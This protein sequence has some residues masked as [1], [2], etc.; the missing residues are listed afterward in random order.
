VSLRLLGGFE[1]RLVPGG[2]IALPKR[3]S[4]ALLA[5]L[6]VGPNGA[7]PRDT[8]TALLWA[9]VPREQA[10]N[11]LRQTLFVLRRAL[12]PAA[13]ELIRTDGDV[14]V[15]DRA[16]MDVDVVA[17]ERL[18]RAEGPEALERAVMLYGGDLLAGLR[19]DETSFEDWLAPRREELR[20]LALRGLQRFLEQQ[21]AQGH[22]QPALETAT[23]LLTLDPLQESAHHAA[24]RLHA[25]QGNIAAALRQYE[26]YRGIV[27]RELGREP[28]VETR[29]LYHA[30]RRRGLSSGPAPRIEIPLIGRS[31]ESDALRQNLEAAWARRTQVVA[32]LGEAGI[33]KS[34][35]VD[36]V[37][38]EAVRRRGHV[39][40]GRCYETQ[41]ILPF[42]PW[43][44]AVRAGGM[45]ADEIIEALPP[46]WR[47]ELARLLPEVDRDRARSPAPPNHPRLFEAFAHLLEQVTA[48]RPL[49]VV[50]EDGH[51]ADE[52]SLRL[53][54]FLA[55][56]LPAARLL[57]VVTVREEEAGDMPVLRQVLAELDRESR[58]T[59]VRLAPLGRAD[60]AALVRALVGHAVAAGLEDEAWSA[61]EGNPFVAVEIVR[62]RTR[63]DVGQAAAT[64][65]LPER[66]QLLVT[67]RLDRLSARGRHLATVAA[68]VGQEASLPLLAL[69]AG[70]CDAEAEDEAAELVQQRI[71]VERPGGMDIA[72]ERVRDAALAGL[73]GARA[74]LLHRRVAEALEAHHAG[75][76]DDHLAAIGSHHLAG[77]AWERAVGFFRLAGDRA[78][79]YGAH[80]EA[81]ACFEHALEALR[82]LPE[83]RA[84]QEQGV[85]LLLNLRHALL[86]LGET[87]RIRDALGRAADL[88]ERL[89]DRRRQ[90]YVAVFLGSY[91]WW[92]GE[93][94]RAYELAA[95]GL[96]SGVDVGDAALCASA[97]YF[98]AVSYE[99]RGSYREAVRLLR[100]LATSTSGGISSAYGSVTA[101]AVFW[102]SHLAR[103]LAELGDFAAARAAADE[104]MRIA[105]PLHHPFLTVHVICSAATVALRQGR[106]D[107]VILQLE[108]LREINASGSAPVVFPINEW[109]LAYAYALVGHPG[110]ADLL[111]RLERLTD[112]ARFTYYYPFWLTLL[113]EGYLLLG[114]VEEALA[115]AGRALELSRKRG[116]RG[117]E[118]WSLRLTGD[119]LWALR[120]RDEPGIADSY[121]SA[122]AIADELGMEPLRAHGH[123]GLG[124]LEHRAGRAAE[125]ERHHGIARQLFEAMAMTRWLPGPPGALTSDVLGDAWDVR[126]EELR[127]HTTDTND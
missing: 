48:T 76:L 83:D 75:R 91:Y 86:P 38:G 73:P 107:E 35:L 42:G 103:S 113:G 44:D 70:M 34:R 11:S 101:P 94:A 69:A 25:E 2:P 40:I 20:A 53:L 31:T 102:T 88:A 98:M 74:R 106:A 64:K 110:A 16:A 122:L 85:D 24:M 39:A 117:N 52:L 66:L 71:F 120:P 111:R 17:F 47:A 56:R 90:A 19:I 23:R 4:Q 55:R 58:L 105:A 30:I 36:E 93:H 62:A 28:G 12:A 89:G 22:V 77:E 121:R 116:E 65:R 92:A 14:V 68:V 109:F 6:A 60:V 79:A 21:L 5:Y 33:G 45:L 99:T 26:T 72:H 87:D 15:V 46:A 41:Q 97:T 43:L 63:G 51:W 112:E 114:Q 18:A 81:A 100:P 37:V 123:L 3:K 95:G 125:A 67:R 32:V 61:S 7:Q 13:P 118:G 84:V 124:R 57:L 108:Q 80:R 54:G 127:R 1:A 82:A 126:G 115:R 50:L 29:D 59:R 78:L 119:A 27:R 49:L 10:R 96:R 9:D 104:A 8:L